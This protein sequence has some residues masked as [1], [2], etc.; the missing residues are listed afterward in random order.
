L[1][2]AGKP[3][4]VLFE[5]R[6]C[7]ECLELHREGFARAEGEQLIG[8]FTA[9]Q[10]D[11]A[12]TRALVTPDGS[13]ANERDWAKALRVTTRP[14]WCSSTPAAT[15]SSGPRVISAPFTSPRLSTTWRPAPTSASPASSASSRRA[16]DGMRAAGKPVDL[17][18]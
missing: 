13:P 3:L 4:A 9:V 5:Q 10:L 6:G 15:R 1:R 16:R 17:W 18:K 2:K 8:R 7:A 12:G 14:A 11:L